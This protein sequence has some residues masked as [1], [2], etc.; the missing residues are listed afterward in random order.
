MFLRKR[1]FNLS[2]ERAV[3]KPAVKDAEGI[4]ITHPVRTTE[5]LGSVKSHSR[6]EDVSNSLL[7]KLSDEEKL[8]LK[9]ALK[10]NEPRVD[11]WFYQLANSLQYAAGE[12]KSCV[13]S[14]GGGDTVKKK[15]V[16]AQMKA[17][18]AAWLDFFKT[19]QVHGLKRKARRPSKAQ[20]PS[21]TCSSPGN[22]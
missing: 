14:I 21:E 19:A 15:Q 22:S 6:F 10:D 1:K 18:D 13:D 20:S 8:E 16:E 7:Q 3:Y 4:I 2:L 5:Y 9:D 17:I 12:I 11:Y